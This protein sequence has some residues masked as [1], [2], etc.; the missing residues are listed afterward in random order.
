M[1]RTASITRNTKETQIQMTFCL[2]GSGQ[3][4]IS[5]GIGFFDHML[6]NFTRH[7]LFDMTLKVTGD[8]EVDTHHTVEDVGIVLGQAISQAAGDKK[9]IV[10]YGSKILPMDEAL[11]LCALDLCGRPYL[12]YDLNLEREFTGDLETEMVKEF[13]YAVSYGAAMNL[14]I[15]QLSGQN[16]HHI[17]EGAFKAFGKA[18]D[19]AV[20]LDSRITDVLSTKG[21]L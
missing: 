12:V 1:K 7:G 21:V 4:D 15:K 18:L 6:N 5:T 17:I 8:L 9:G 2:D 10:R 20:Q 16:C 14:H 3:A 11:I 19:Q 13:F